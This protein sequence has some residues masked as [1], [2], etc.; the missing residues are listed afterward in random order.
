MLASAT[1]IGYLVEVWGG[2][3]INMTTPSHSPEMKR[4]ERIGEPS[5]V[6]CA[7]DLSVHCQYGHPGILTAAIRQQ[8]TG[9]GGTSL[10]SG[11]TVTAEHI[12]GIEHPGGSFW[13]QYVWTPRAGFR[14]D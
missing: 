6:I 4:L 3:G 12:G 5:V 1:Q 14:R 7:L 13:D 11:V 8:L 2:E 10:Q 9:S